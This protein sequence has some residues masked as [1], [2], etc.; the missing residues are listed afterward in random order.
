MTALSFS[1]RVTS[2]IAPPATSTPAKDMKPIGPRQTATLLLSRSK[3]QPP[4]ATI[5][6]PNTVVVH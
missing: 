4:F 2:G 1:K 5:G 6:L 3:G